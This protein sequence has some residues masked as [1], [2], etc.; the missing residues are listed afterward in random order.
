MML[1]SLRHV[2]SCFAIAL[3][4]NSTLISIS[5]AQASSAAA[6]SGF[7]YGDR[8]LQYAS[9][10][11]NNL[12]W[13]GV[14][15][16][17]RYSTEEIEQELL[18]GQDAEETSS[19]DLNR[20]RFK[21]GGHLF[22]PRFAVYSEYDFPTDRLIDLRATYE[23]SEGFNVRVGQ[24]KGEFNRERVDSSGA[25]QF[26]ERSISTPWFTIDRQQGVVAS[27]RLWPTT[28]KD[29]S[30]WVGW[31]SGAG[32][33]GDWDEA[34]GLWLGRYQWNFTGELLGFSQSDIGRRD[35]GVGS[36]AIGW[37]E[38]ETQYTSFSSAGGGQLPGFRGGASDKYELRQAVFET[39]YQYQGYSWQ[40]E[41]H[42]KQIRDR[43]TGRQRKITGGY[44][45]FGVFLSSLF[46]TAPEPLEIALR[47]AMVEP[48]SILEA[49]SEKEYTLAANW[50]F[51]GHRNK[52]TAD[53]SWVEQKLLPETQNRTRLRLQWDW[54]F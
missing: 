43:R 26:A 34:E 5:S 19:T 25:Q 7:S 9:A 41:W 11:G 44:A 14:R 16:Q 38:G 17:S 12:L 4:V 51:N 39:A 3:V 54:S 24:W 45:Q 10:D 36:V 35:Q 52:L 23:F 46:A 48:D 20:G 28:A 50:F 13:F 40:Q 1:N 37:V 33:G 53:I 15:L 27:G 32:R 22:S 6:G 42:W 47:A 21:L 29:S 18:S 31:L 2:F 49:D 30:Y 8:G